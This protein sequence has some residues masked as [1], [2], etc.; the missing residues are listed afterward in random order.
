M[1]EQRPQVRVG[2]RERDLVISVLHDA[3][4]EGRLTA[5]EGEDRVEAALRA[6]TFADLDPLVADLPVEPPSTALAGSQVQPDP[7][8]ILDPGASAA[9]RLVLDA[10]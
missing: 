10:G 4:A 8:S 2:D 6:R 3:L 1:P 7:R 9:D 5:A